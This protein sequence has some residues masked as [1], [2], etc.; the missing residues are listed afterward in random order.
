VSAALHDDR[1]NPPFPSFPN[2]IT[3]GAPS[4]SGGRMMVAPTIMA[5]PVRDGDDVKTV[6]ANL[7][8]YHVGADGKLSFVNNYEV[9][10]GNAQQFWSGM[11]RWVR[12][13]VM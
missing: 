13:V 1:T 11:G 8:T 7:A 3:I 4:R 10:T 12:Q 5:A 6:P 9:D 2:G